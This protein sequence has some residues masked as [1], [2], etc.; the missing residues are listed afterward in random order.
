[1]VRHRPPPWCIIK[2]PL[3]MYVA[4]VPFLVWLDIMVIF[5]IGGTLLRLYRGHQN[6][7]PDFPFDFRSIPVAYF[8]PI[9]I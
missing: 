1:M 4:H 9:K 5:N 6:G 3:V 8:F 7:M 2:G